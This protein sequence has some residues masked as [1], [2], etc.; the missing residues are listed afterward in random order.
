MEKSSQA[1]NPAQAGRVACL[2]ELSHN[3]FHILPVMSKPRGLTLQTSYI[4]N[5]NNEN[6]HIKNT[7]FLTKGLWIPPSK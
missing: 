3:I 2:Y 4:M 1:G 5:Q 6:Q 7:R